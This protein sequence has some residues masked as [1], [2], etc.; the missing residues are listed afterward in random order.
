M[1]IEHIRQRLR[2]HDAKPVHE[3]RVLRLWSQAL[4][5]DQGRN[6]PEDFFPLSLRAALP[7]LAADLAGLA[8]PRAEH[9]GEDGSAR[10]LVELADGRTVESVLLPRDGCASPPRWAARWAACSA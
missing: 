3:H 8:R 5:Y 6:R 1:R 10:L 4:P 2:A 7:A 9:P